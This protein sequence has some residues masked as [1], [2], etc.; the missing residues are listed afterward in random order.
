MRHQSTQGKASP[1]G[2][3][4]QVGLELAEWRRTH[5]APTPIPEDLWAR[6]A[7]LAAQHGTGAV[8]RALC[9]NHTQLKRRM[10]TVPAAGPTLT[11]VELLPP[12]MPTNIGECAMEVESHRGSRMRVVLKDVPPLC[13]AGL[14]REFVG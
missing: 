6:A 7:A 13:L 9:L 4:E 3:L 14:L 1:T 10:A 11:F 5:H 8:A 2:C 12:P